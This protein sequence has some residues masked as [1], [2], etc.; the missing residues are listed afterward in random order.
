M[1][2]FPTLKMLPEIIELFYRSQVGLS[3]SIRVVPE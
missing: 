3:I 1:T 2:V